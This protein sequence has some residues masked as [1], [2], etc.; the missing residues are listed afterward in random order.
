MTHPDN[1][2][3]LSL[4]SAVRHACI[5]CPVFNDFPTFEP[6]SCLELQTKARIT[7][8]RYSSAEDLGAEETTLCPFDDLLVY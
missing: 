3:A 6:C 2:Y 5:S 7:L 1:Q 8:L 4:L